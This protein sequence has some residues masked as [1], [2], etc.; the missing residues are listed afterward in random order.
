MPHKNGTGESNIGNNYCDIEKMV[1][2]MNGNGFI[3]LGRRINKEESSVL[4]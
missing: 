2:C 1:G 3:N 4:L